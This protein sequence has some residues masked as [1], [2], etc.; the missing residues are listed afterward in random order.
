MLPSAVVYEQM[1]GLGAWHD[2]DGMHFVKGCSR[3]MPGD[4][5]CCIGHACMG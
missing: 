3:L 2:V 1:R 5:G 4:G